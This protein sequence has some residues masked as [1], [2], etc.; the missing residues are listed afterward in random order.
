M[1][2][3]LT[4]LGSRQTDRKMT[5]SIHVLWAAVPCFPPSSMHF[6]CSVIYWSDGCDVSG[7]GVSI[8]RWPLTENNF[9]KSRYYWSRVCICQFNFIYNKLKRRNR[10]KNWMFHLTIACHRLFPFQSNVASWPTNLHLIGTC[11]KLAS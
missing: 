10:V 9:K 11:S 7:V 8:R 6:S 1:I 2:N 4:C 3:V 5:D